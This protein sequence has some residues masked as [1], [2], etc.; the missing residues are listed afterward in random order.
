MTGAVT[1]LDRYVAVW[2][3]GFEAI[4]A[5]WGLLPDAIGDLAFKAANGLIAGVEAM[6][7]GVVTRINSF[8]SGINAALEMLPDWAVGEGGVQIGTLDPLSLERIANPFEGSAADA[9]A[10]AAGA[11]AG[12]WERTY[13]ETPDL[14]GDLA[15]EAAAAASAHLETAQVLGA[16]AVAPLESW[17]A[18]KDAVTASGE[19]GANALDDAAGAAG[20]AGAA[21]DSAGGA[22]GRAAA[23]GRKAGAGMKEAADEALRGWDAV[24][25]SLSDYAGKARDI[26]GYIGNALVNAFQSAENAVGDFV[27][28]GKLNFR[29]LV[30]SLLADLAK[31]GARRFL[32]GPLAGVLSGALGGMG[33]GVLASILHSGGMVGAGGAGRMVP[34]MAFASAPRM[35]SGGW[36]GLRSDE[37]P[38]ILQR[39]ERVLSRRE[40]AS[41]AGGVTININAR[42][43]ESFRQSRAQISADI[44]RA[45]AMGRR[46][47]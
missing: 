23:A 38:A 45:V 37:V 29:D 20:R 6:L 42:D 46:G 14:F 26:G 47:M 2:H 19:E 28:S 7:N 30:T 1:A 15:A 5:I 40:V 18:L 43:A 36:A 31:L 17:Q 32:L 35:H 11:F 44:A 12:A 3:G 39:G 24:A 27:K 4:K 16:A 41:G 10:A 22:A 13:I 33:G 25:A 8:I 9:G 21:L 34:A